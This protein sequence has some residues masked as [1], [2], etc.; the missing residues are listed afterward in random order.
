MKHPKHIT[1]SVKLAT[2]LALIV[3]SAQV[4]FASPAHIVELPPIKPDGLSGEIKIG[5]SPAAY[6]LTRKIADDFIAEGFKS[7]LAIVSEDGAAGIARFCKGEIDI[8]E[9]DRPMLPAEIEACEKNNRA[10]I[11]FKVGTDAV[12]FAVSR[13]N[14]FIDGLTKAQLRHIFSGKA[15]TWKD[16]NPNWP[17]TNIRLYSLPKSLTNYEYVTTQ[18][19]TGVV[20]DVVPPETTPNDIIA[21][22][23]GIVLTDSLPL[24]ARSVYSDVFALTYVS[25]AYYSKNRAMLRAVPYEG[26]MANDRTLLSGDYRLT[27]PLFIAVAESDVKDK[28]QV[29]AFVNYYLANVN[30][31]I[32]DVGYF[33]ETEK[34][35][36]ESKTRWLNL[37]K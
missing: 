19:F 34:A 3:A 5:G 15:K 25:Y 22:V 23:P 24:I 14:R 17:A 30:R 8:V 9:M 4:S 18:L 12:I 11:E 37:L 16:V 36:D 32:G 27:R 31:A 10:P 13:K 6:P 1:V 35:L 2:C 7:D 20:T 21:R 28:P 29:A 33:A 26:V